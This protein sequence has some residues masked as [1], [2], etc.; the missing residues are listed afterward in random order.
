MTIPWSGGRRRSPCGG[1][2]R[3]GWGT[4][5]AF[6]L[7]AAGCGNYSNEDLEFMNAIPQRGDVAVE[8]P[9][10]ANLTAADSAE[11]WLTTFKVTRDFNHVADAFLSL[12]DTIRSFYPTTR[13]ANER[14]WGPVA[15]KEHPGWQIEFRMTKSEAPMRRFN[16]VLVMLPPAGVVLHSGRQEVQIIGGNFDAAGGAGTGTGSGLLDVTL[17][18]ARQEGVIFP[19][20]ESLRSLSIDYDARDWPRR[21]TMTLLNLPSVVPVSAA[22]THE[23]WQNGD[24][25]MR[26][27]FEQEIPG[28]AGLQT[29]LVES[30]WLG[31]GPGRSD[32]SVT[33]GSAT[34]L[35][36]SVECW[37]ETF[38][39]I[40]KLQSWDPD[41]VFGDAG[42]CIAQ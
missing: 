14:I 40:Y 29:L 5:C 42:T 12:I 25:T 26:F 41:G 34:G 1:S 7:A 17:D 32:L 21:T 30:R 38:R 22:Y 13:N 4:T 9:R 23:H 20:L 35:A 24:G 19:N 28:F 15:S 8:L 11:G 2:W 27:S 3:V 37:N 18:V 16:Y 6:L 39:S 36:S 31:A 33:A 10:R